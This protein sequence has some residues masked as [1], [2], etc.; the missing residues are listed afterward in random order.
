MLNKQTEVTTR[1][2]KKLSSRERDIDL[3]SEEEVQAAI[4]AVYGQPILISDQ[5]MAAKRICQLLGF[6]RV[7]LIMETKVNQQIQKLMSP[8]K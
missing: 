1:N 7:S 6:G 8:S 5:N 4:I 3:I 2:R